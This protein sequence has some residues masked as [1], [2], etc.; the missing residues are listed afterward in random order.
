ME[1][2]IYN[3]AWYDILS[4]N[5]GIKS[6]TINCMLV[7]SGYVPNKRT[8]SRRSDVRDEVTGSG[9]TAG[10]MSISSSVEIVQ[11]TD[12][13]YLVLGAARWM[14]STII[15]NGAAYYN[16]R[17]KDPG[18]DELIA[19]VAFKEK[20]ISINGDFSLQGLSLWVNNSE[21]LIV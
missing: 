9:Y 13:I 21:Y 14:H 1:S 12:M 15:A 2:L 17:G 5:I 10:G 7:G 19:F 20:N 11:G 8:H 18:D 6:G 3:S 4:G 16:S